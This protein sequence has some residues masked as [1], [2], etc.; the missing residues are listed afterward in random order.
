MGPLVSVQAASLRV[1]HRFIATVPHLACW[2]L[3]HQLA[4]L[5]GDLAW[6]N[7]IETYK[8]CSINTLMV[9]FLCTLEPAPEGR[10]RWMVSIKDTA[11]GH[12]CCGV[13][14]DPQHILTA[15]HCLD[16]VW[17]K[18]LLASTPIVHIGPQRWSDN[19]STPGVQ[20]VKPF[21]LQTGEYC[22]LKCTF[23]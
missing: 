16:P 15:A 23:L 5:C 19:C 13:L 4:T 2:W 17:Q 9:C 18:D 6:R 14:I 12:I 10:F 7:K 21:S 22:T 20:V 3:N 11:H 8:L 1:S